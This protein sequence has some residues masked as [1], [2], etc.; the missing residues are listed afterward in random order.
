M[1]TKS[2]RE[3]F[4]NALSSLGLVKADKAERYADPG[5]NTYLTWRRDGVMVALCSGGLYEHNGRVMIGCAS[6]VRDVTIAALI[7]DADRRMTGIASLLLDELCRLAEAHNV[8]LYAQPTPIDTDRLKR[9]RG[10]AAIGLPPGQWCKRKKYLREFYR[11][12][13]FALSNLDGLV[14]HFNEPKGAA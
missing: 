11:Q 12:R 7:V 6:D 4:F 3:G 9:G 14:A 5:G 13:G 2:D 8:T 1:S 10:K